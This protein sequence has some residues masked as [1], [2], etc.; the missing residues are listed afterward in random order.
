MAPRVG[1]DEDGTR[2]TKIHN[3]GVRGLTPDFVSQVLLLVTVGLAIYDPSLELHILSNF[4]WK[5]ISE[6]KDTGMGL[7]GYHVS[8]KVLKMRDFSSLMP[9]RFF[10]QVSPSG[11]TVYVFIDANDLFK[12]SKVANAIKLQTTQ[13]IWMDLGKF[14]K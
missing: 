2:A 9:T 12:A 6:L 8:L 5:F 11:D 13:S 1:V 4:R 7:I 14:A 3:Y 10:H